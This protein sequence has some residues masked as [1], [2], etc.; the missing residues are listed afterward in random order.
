MA[1]THPYDALIVGAG[2]AGL[3]CAGAA[4]GRGL[5][6]LLVDKNDRPGRKLRIT[7]KGRCN[8]TNNCD[9]DAF[10]RAVR[11]NPRFLYSAINGFSTADTMALFEEL[12][13][14]LKTERGNRVFP[15]SDRAGD[16][17]DALCRYVKR[18]GAAF[19]KKEAEGLLLDEGRVKGVICKDGTPLFARRVVIATGG[20]SYPGTGSTGDGYRL[21]E[22]AGHTIVPP[23]P[24]LVPIVTVEDYCREM[25]GL[26]LK[27]VTLT[28][29][30]A[31]KKKP[32][33]SE[34]GEMLFTHFGVSGPLVLSASSHMTGDLADYKMTIDLKP[35]L[36]LHQLDARLLRDFGKFS[37]KDFSN[38]LDELLPRKLIPV[39]VRLSGIEADRKVHQITREERERLAALI[40]GFPVTPER[41]RPVEEAIVTSGGVYVRQVDPHTMES[42]LCPG[43]YFAGEV[44]DL[45]AYTG[46]YNLQIAFST[47]WLAAAAMAAENEE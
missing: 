36:D 25:M 32:V 30:K 44:L 31:G 11:R 28:V 8:V 26:A 20:L 4:A 29:W 3:L 12:G 41:F 47:G 39:V 19:H 24:S 15:V 6:V 45:D 2:A 35:G 33:F 7:G 1:N 18:S 37:N 46:G 40:K 16:I 13:V 43:L 23:V 38:A 22:Q 34:L 9:N 42:R 17:V 5:S 10:L 21:A 27:N 14:P